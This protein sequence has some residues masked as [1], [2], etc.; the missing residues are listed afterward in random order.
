MPLHQ[1]DA[2]FVRLP[3]PRLRTAAQPS[4]HSDSAVRSVYLKSKANK[5]NGARG[6]LRRLEALLLADGAHAAA[7]QECPGL[8]VDPSLDTLRE[9]LALLPAG[10]HWASSWTLT[11]SEAAVFVYDRRAFDPVLI[12]GKE[13]G[14]CLEDPNNKGTMAA[15]SPAIQ[16]TGIA[17][18]DG[19]HAAA[20]C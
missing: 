9:C 14:I 8:G 4:A 1:A 16:V 13:C 3:L 15:I 5:L 6:K 11:H 10:P 17:T 12:G 7:L 19:A 18:V 2:P 20:V